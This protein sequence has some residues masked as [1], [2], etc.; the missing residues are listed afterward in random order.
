MPSLPAS[1]LLPPLSSHPPKFRVDQRGTFRNF[2]Q[3]F[4]RGGGG[5]G[6][7]AHAVVIMRKVILTRFD[8]NAERRF[9]FRGRVTFSNLVQPTW[10]LNCGRLFLL[11]LPLLEIERERENSVNVVHCRRCNV[12]RVK[13]TRDSQAEKAKQP[14]SFHASL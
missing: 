4:V 1:S 3:A 5:G 6:R 10:K 12:T 9:H 2:N 11:L 8:G 14:L 7:K 13:T